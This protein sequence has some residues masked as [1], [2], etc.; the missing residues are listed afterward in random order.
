MIRKI[1]DYETDKEQEAYT[2]D[3][4]MLSFYSVGLNSVDLFT[5][6]DY[7]NGR[8]YY[9]RSKTRGRRKD[10]AAGSIKVGP[11]T[12]PL[13]EKYKDKTGQRV[14]DFYTRHSNFKAFIIF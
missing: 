6:C 9:E 8:L 13:L 12:M 4:F 14:F 1:R 11:E 2:R 10:M 5:V 3:V 7:W